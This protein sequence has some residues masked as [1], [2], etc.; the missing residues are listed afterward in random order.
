MGIGG[1]GLIVGSGRSDD[2]PVGVGIGKQL[3]AQKQ[4]GAPIT[5]MQRPPQNLPSGVRH[6]LM[7]AMMLCASQLR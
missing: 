7:H 2:D 1:P 3:S 4:T 5:R 6:F